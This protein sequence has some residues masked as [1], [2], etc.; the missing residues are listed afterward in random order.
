MRPQRQTYQISLDD[1][2]PKRRNWGSAWR[3]SGKGCG[4]GKLR[5]AIKLLTTNTHQY[6]CTCDV[7]GGRNNMPKQS[8]QLARGRNVP[9]RH[10]RATRVKVRSLIRKTKQPNPTSERQSLSSALSEWRNLVSRSVSLETNLH[11]IH[12]TRK[13]EYTTRC[14]GMLR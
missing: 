7:K 9:H 11:Q 10:C 4:S 8:S 3:R 12:S 1:N 13:S 14:V 2:D 5:G 6:R